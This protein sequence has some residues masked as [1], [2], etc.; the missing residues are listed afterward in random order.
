MYFRTAIYF[1]SS[2]IRWNVPITMSEADSEH[3]SPAVKISMPDGSVQQ[4]LLHPFLRP[5]APE[6]DT[7]RTRAREEQFST[8]GDARHSPRKKGENDKTGRTAL[9]STG[10]SATTETATSAHSA[11][12]IVSASDHTASSPVFTSAD[13]GTSS[14]SYSLELA[15]LTVRYKRH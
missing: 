8:R 6:R 7:R 11:V 15:C 13:T 14:L 9:S 10:S 1:R 5:N 2:V 4:A 12:V 3:S